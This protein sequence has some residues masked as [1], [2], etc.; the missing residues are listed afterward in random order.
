MAYLKLISFGGIAQQISPRLIGENIAQTAE[1]V[2]LD[3]GRLVPL[4][5]NT[6]SYTLSTTGQNSIF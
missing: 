3:S 5:N 4:R 1:D 6:D 2:L